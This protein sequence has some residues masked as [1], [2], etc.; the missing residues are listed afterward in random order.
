MTSLA[1]PANLAPLVLYASIL[2]ATATAVARRDTAL[3]WALGFVVVPFLPASNLFFP[4]G[5]I[6]A[7]RVRGTVVIPVIVVVE[8]RRYSESAG[9][10]AASQW[11]GYSEPVYLYTSTR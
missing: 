9:E 1:D 2:A 5:A 11:S 6:V 7:E 8:D 10:S 4:V 3:M